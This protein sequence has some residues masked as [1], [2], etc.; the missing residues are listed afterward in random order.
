MGHARLCAHPTPPAAVSAAKTR[1]RIR[2][3][4]ASSRLS[5][6]ISRRRARTRTRSA[7]STRSSSSEDTTMSDRPSSAS[8]AMTA[9]SSAFAPMSIPRANSSMSRTSGC[10]WSHFATT[11]FCWLPPEK[12]SAGELSRLTSKARG[13]ATSFARL[14][15]RRLLSTGPRATA[16]M[17][18]SVMFVAALSERCSPSDFRSSGARAIP[19]LSAART[20][21]GQGTSS[22]LTKSRPRA[23][24]SAPANARSSSVLPEPTRPAIPSISPRRRVNA[25]SSSAPGIVRP[26]IRSRML[27]PTGRRRSGGLRSALPSIAVTRPCFVHDL[28]SFVATSFPS[29]MTDTRSQCSRTS[30]RACEMKIVET[31]SS[32]SPRMTS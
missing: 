7:A 16:R 24:G 18:L 9:S 32:L 29:R 21:R 12:I 15:C 31:P 20:V 10:R 2:S 14:S 6:A 23:V 25:R 19:S 27:S 3:T 5:S 13:P 4:D 11:S 28:T 30:S 17:S 22:P 8:F 1:R 26:A